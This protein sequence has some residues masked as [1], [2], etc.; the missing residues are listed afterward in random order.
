MT[1]G[2]SIFIFD[3]QG[4]FLWSGYFFDGQGIFFDGEVFFF[5]VKVFFLMVKVFILMVRYFFFQKNKYLHHQK[6]IL[7]PSIFRNLPVIFDLNTFVIW[8][9]EWC[10]VWKHFVTNLLKTYVLLPRYINIH[11]AVSLRR[12]KIK[13]TSRRNVRFSLSLYSLFL[14][15]FS[16][17]LILLS[18]VSAA[19]A[20]DPG[21]YLGDPCWIGTLS[22]NWSWNTACSLRLTPFMSSSLVSSAAPGSGQHNGNVLLTHDDVGERRKQ[23]ESRFSV[24]HHLK[25]QYYPYRTVQKDEIGNRYEMHAPNCTNK[26]TKL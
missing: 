1:A 9:W 10:Y 22:R 25:Q 17:V 18:S 6:K 20:G 24:F 16:S 5:M 19:M 15:S 13:I 3:G 26:F 8:L 14:M 7:L 21:W 23:L 12:P 11:C 4:I 2:G